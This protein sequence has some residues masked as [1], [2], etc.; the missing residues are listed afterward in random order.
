MIK[1][2][3]RDCGRNNYTETVYRSLLLWMGRIEV[4]SI[5]KTLA[6][7]FQSFRTHL[8]EKK[9]ECTMDYSCKKL[10]DVLVLDFKAMFSARVKVSEKDFCIVLAGKQQ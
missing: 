1:F 5:L 10:I 6:S 3:F 4:D 8:K 2:V 7:F 9:Q